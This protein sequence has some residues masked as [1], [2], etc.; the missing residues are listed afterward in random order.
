MKSRKQLRIGYWHFK[1]GLIPL[2][3]TSHTYL[4]HFGIFKLIPNPNRE[5][6]TEIGPGDYK[7]FWFRKQF[8]FNGFEWSWIQKDYFDENYK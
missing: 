2:I 5:E 7:G 6:G 8:T 1:L 4:L 3:M